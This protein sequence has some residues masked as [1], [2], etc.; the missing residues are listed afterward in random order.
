MTT[1]SAV[2]RSSRRPSRGRTLVMAP[3]LIAL[4]VLYLSPILWMVLAS[5]KTRVDI[6]ASTP[7]LAF[8]PTLANYAQAFQDKGFMTNL[9]NSGIV[10]LLTTAI[11]LAV[12][13][14]A[15]Y[16]IS[17]SKGRFGG[18]Y[19]LAL[20]A[21]RLMPAMVLSV[22]LFV[23]ATKIGMS[24]SYLAVVAAHLTFSIPFTVWMMRSFFLAVPASLDEAALLDGLGEFGVF[25]RVVLPLTK[26]G[27][28]ATTVFC[29]INSW[30]EFLFALVLTGRDTATLPVAVPTL[31][32]PI[33]TFWGQI[34]AVGTVTVV[35]IAIFAF[36]VQRYIITG[37]TGGALS[38][39]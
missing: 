15:A 27:I 9:V 32:T 12:G 2:V 30:N 14:P 22:P 25:F 13:V 16:Q 36:L 3:L 23:L 28:A 5:F 4:A 7:R 33:G 35:P 1:Q 20:L 34:A 21:A 31:L 38:G 37:M 29:L 18:L 11:A 19:M 17:R 10:A 26:G 39:E 8:A 6:F 24:G